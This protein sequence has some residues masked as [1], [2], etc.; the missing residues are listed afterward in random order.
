MWSSFDA[1]RKDAERSIR[2]GW[3][4]VIASI[5]FHAAIVAIP[6]RDRTLEQ[7]IGGTTKSPMS[8]VIVNAPTPAPTPLT[9]PI[10]APESPKAP[11]PEPKA[12]R[13]AATSPR[14]STTAPQTSSPPATQTI[15]SPTAPPQPAMDMASLIAARRAQRQST[16]HEALAFAQRRDQGPLLPQSSADQAIQR[17]LGSLAQGS[18][19][20]SGVFQ[21]LRKGQRTAEFA[22]NGWKPDVSKRWRQVI[23]VDAGVGGDVELALI[24]GMIKIIREHYSG[25]FNWQSYKQGK[26]IVLSARQQDNEKLEDFLSS[27]FFGTPVLRRD[28]TAQPIPPG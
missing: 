26:V 16:E 18:E 13:V 4:A 22:F 9:T 10:Q 5:L 12:P 2:R 17:N 23:E 8:V 20:T 1:R 28:R 7:A 6:S 27:E 19:G 24:R 21:I 25:D 3:V 15:P 11:A 14:P